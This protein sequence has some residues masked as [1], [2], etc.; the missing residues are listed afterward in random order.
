M[1]MMD[2][3]FQPKA[4][5]FNFYKFA[6]MQKLYFALGHKRSRRELSCIVCSL[7]YLLFLLAWFYIRNR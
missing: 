1:M 2:M 5:K 4:G 7:A 3:I 6:Q